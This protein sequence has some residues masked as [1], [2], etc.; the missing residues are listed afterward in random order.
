MT[1]K[2]KVTSPALAQCSLQLY[3][4]RT[5]LAQQHW[6]SAHDKTLTEWRIY[7][8][9]SHSRGRIHSRASR[10]SWQ[11]HGSA[12]PLTELHAGCRVSPEVQAR[13]RKPPRVAVVGPPALLH[14]SSRRLPWRLL[15][16]SVDE[17][18]SSFC[19]ET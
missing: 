19:C 6:L 10:V 11:Y 14:L 5:A 17:H 16:V 1:C 7:G 2:P 9:K 4:Q 15:H 3:Q 13:L 18:A 12:D 8:S